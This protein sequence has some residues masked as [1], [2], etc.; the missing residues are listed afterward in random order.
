M[1]TLKQ[2]KRGL[3]LRPTYDQVLANYLSGGP[4]IKKPD[5]TATFIRESPEYQSLLKFNFVDLQKQ[6]EDI[7]KEQKKVILINEQIGA[8]GFDTKSVRA[9]TGSDFGSV[10]SQQLED[11]ENVN[12]HDVSMRF[13]YESAD[14]YLQE[15][16]DDKNYKVLLENYRILS[17]S[18][19]D[20]VNKQSEYLGGLGGAFDPQ[21]ISAMG[22]AS[23]SAAPQQFD[24]SDEGQPEV[25]HKSRQREFLQKQ[26]V[27]ELKKYAD[28]LAIRFPSGMKK[29]DIIEL[30]INTPNPE[31]DVEPRGK[32]GRPRK[33]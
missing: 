23:S 13:E 32:R 8:S 30:L 16:E 4:V 20:D 33:Y 5:R 2:M 28:P 17:K 1:A 21:S 18:F 31:T 15:L 9:N 25:A 7:L 24:I 22:S 26:T 11:L 10:V 3:E 12:S 14:A 29:N 6:Q 19:I 27:A